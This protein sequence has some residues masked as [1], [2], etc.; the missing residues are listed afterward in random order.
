MGALGFRLNP[1]YGFLF[2]IQWGIAYD[3]L[4][5]NLDSRVHGD[6]R[7]VATY[8]NGLYAP[9]TLH[10]ELRAPFYPFAD[11]YASAGNY[12]R[13]ETNIGYMQLRGGIR[14][15][16]VTHTLVDLYTRVNVVRDSRGIM[17]LDLS[18]SVVPA[19]EKKF[20]NNLVE[21]GF[22]AR[23]TPHTEWGLYFAV[24]YLRGSYWGIPDEEIP[25]TYERWYNSL[26]SFIIFERTF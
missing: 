2:D 21:G 15:L 14:V 10:E 5:K 20:Y 13:Y 3:L 6:F 25:A 16:E 4:D 7:A 12:S 17:S 11:V 22:G 26:R 18:S 8:S 19:Q 23:L 1:F 24:E 9:F